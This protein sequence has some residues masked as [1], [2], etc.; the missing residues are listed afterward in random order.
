VRLTSTPSR[1]TTLVRGSSDTAPMSMRGDARSARPPQ[2]RPHSRHDLF[3]AE[4]LHDIVV[5]AGFDAVHPLVPVAARGQHQDRHIAPAFRQRLRAVRAVHF[6]QAE[7]EHDEIERLAVA[8]EPGFLA[9]AD[10]VDGKARGLERS[11]QRGRDPLVI[12][13]NQDAHVSA[14]AAP[15]CRS[16]SSK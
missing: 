9:V 12:L 7:V 8:P 3:G 1:V 10:P 16:R 4:G 6:G 5:S 2:D 15:A 13:G 14:E 11:G